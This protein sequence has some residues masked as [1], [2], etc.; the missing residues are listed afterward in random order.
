M[1]KLLVFV[2]ILTSLIFGVQGFSQMNSKEFEKVI[3][4]V[5]EE[6]D[7][8]NRQKAISMLKE[9]IQK[10]P[11]NVVLKAVLG[12]LYDD[13]GKK[14]ESEKEL[15]EAIEMQKKYPFIADDGKK[16]DI[17][18]LTAIVYMGMEEYEK[19]LKWLSKIDNKNLESGDDINF[20]M[21]SLNYRLENTEE[22]KKYLLKSYIKDEE[23]MSQNILG[24]IYLAEGNQKE[25]RKWFLE[26]SDKGNSG[27]QANLGFLYQMLGDKEKALK[28]MTKALETAKKEKNAEQ[29][30]EIQEMIE[31]VKNN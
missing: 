2:V 13:M 22:A 3:E 1:K 29:V 5:S 7:K 12:M 27:G 9:D 17:R 24:Q 6:Y 18:L 28:W 23:G 31:S 19:A 11:T 20:I 15:N 4:K 26:S 8:G 21:G 25:A 10:N 16:Y 14:N 30:K